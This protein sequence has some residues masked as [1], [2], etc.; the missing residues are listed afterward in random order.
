MITFILVLSISILIGDAEAIQCH[1]CGNELITGTP[2]GARGS[3]WNKCKDGDDLGNL[4]DCAGG[5]CGKYTTP[6]TGEIFLTMN[7]GLACM[8]LTF[9]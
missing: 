5:V 2:G 4:V 1:Q 7:S 6:K 9:N 8:T 3:L